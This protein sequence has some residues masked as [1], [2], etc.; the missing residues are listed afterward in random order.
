MRKKR[1]ATTGPHL[2]SQESIRMVRYQMCY[3]DSLDNIILA[4]I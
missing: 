1:P 2:E 4:R 3:N